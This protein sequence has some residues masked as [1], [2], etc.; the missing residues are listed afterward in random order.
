MNV[1]SQNFQPIVEIVLQILVVHMNTVIL[2][3]IN[4]DS[5]V[6]NLS[7]VLVRFRVHNLVLDNNHIRHIFNYHLFDRIN[8]KVLIGINNGFLNV[9]IKDLIQ[10]ILEV[11]INKILLYFYSEIENVSVIVKDY[12]NLFI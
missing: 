12:L 11:R 2:S 8:N 6:K 1:S 7:I 10:D 5:F 4:I 9:N 3:N